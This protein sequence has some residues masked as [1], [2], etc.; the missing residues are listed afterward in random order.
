MFK[1]IKRKRIITHI[2]SVISTIIVI[3]INALLTRIF[4]N[5]YMT[6]RIRFAI[7]MFLPLLMTVITL[8]LCITYLISELYILYKT[9]VNQ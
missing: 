3:I 8:A 6:S 2:K 4:F 5:A 1:E 9:A 7:L